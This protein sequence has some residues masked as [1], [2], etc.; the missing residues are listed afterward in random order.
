VRPTIKEGEIGNVTQIVLRANLLAHLHI[1][2]GGGAQHAEA[3]GVVEGRIVVIHH[4][5]VVHRHRGGLGDCGRG[6]GSIVVHGF[7]RR[8]KFGC[9]L[10]LAAR[11]RGERRQRRQGQ[12]QD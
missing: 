1:V 11:R 10:N 6:L 9:G 12:G 3:R 5:A 2:E 4:L 7:Y 8:G